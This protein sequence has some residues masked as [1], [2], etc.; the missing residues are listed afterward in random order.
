MKKF[1]SFQL[2]II[3]GIAMF[4][5]H[6]A[7]FIQGTPLWFH[8]IG[9]IA[10]PVFFYLLVEGFFHTRSKKGYIKRLAI[11]GII[12]LIGS[13]ILMYIFNRPIKIT[14]NILISMA[15]NLM[16]LS[17][18]EWKKE[19]NNKGLANLSI[20]ISFFLTLF[21]EGSILTTAM[22][23]IFYFNRENKTK[24]CFWYILCSLLILTNPANSI[25]ESLFVQNYQWMMV[26]SL[27]FILMYN[28]ERGRKAKYFFYI[29]YPV[30]IWTLYVI[31]NYINF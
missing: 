26:F 2:K 4:I 8:Y 19:A 5:D 27:P 15:L 10:A 9:R 28:G 18:I 30:H 16:L 3:M 11:S 23:L 31:G 13:S 25:Y 20:G 14:N 29:F 7:E 1:N 12:M 24:M 21:A 6:V 17:S 22:T